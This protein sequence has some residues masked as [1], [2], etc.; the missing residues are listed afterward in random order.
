MSL[1][2][3]ESLASHPGTTTHSGVPAEVRER[4][5][6]HEM[7]VR[8]SIGIEHPDDIVADLAQALD[9]AGPAN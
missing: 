7:T 4:I 1:G 9:R 3:T 2:G 5:G 8:L 6:V